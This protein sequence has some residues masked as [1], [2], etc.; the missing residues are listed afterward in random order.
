MRYVLSKF[1][2]DNFDYDNEVFDMVG[3]ADPCI[4][5]RALSD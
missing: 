1:D 3:R 2:Y 4:V 5:G